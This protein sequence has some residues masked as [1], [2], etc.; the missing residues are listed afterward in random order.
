MRERLPNRHFNWRAWR[1][2]PRT[3]V[4]VSP[5]GGLTH[6]ECLRNLLMGESFPSK[7]HSVDRVH[8]TSSVWKVELLSQPMLLKLAGVTLKA[9]LVV[10]GVGMAGIMPV[11]V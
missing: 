4:Q 9:R 1:F 8:S 10:A 7:F 2:F 5:N 3:A 6:S 11:R